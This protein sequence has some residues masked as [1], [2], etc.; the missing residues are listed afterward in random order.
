MIPFRPYNV[1]IPKF[2]IEDFLKGGVGSF[3]KVF[4]E[5]DIVQDEYLI[6]IPAKNATEVR[7]I[8]ERLLGLGFSYDDGIQRSDDFA[9][10]AKEGM[11][12]N[13]PWLI[14]GSEG[15]CWFIADVEAPADFS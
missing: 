13:V 15:Q 6:A 3:L 7:D 9:V 8:F 12:W 14:M 2:K 4:P 1:L 10:A 5:A 11:W